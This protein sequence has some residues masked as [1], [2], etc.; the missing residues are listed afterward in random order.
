MILGSLC[1]V[2][3]V[4]LGEPLAPGMQ[5]PVITLADQ[6]DVEAKIGP[7]T[8]LLVFARDMDAAKIVE[9][10]LEE[11]GAAILA[12]AA[13]VFVSDIHR[14]PGIITRLFALPSMRKRPYRMLLDREGAATADLPSQDEKV[15]LIR[16][17]K[18]KIESV[19]YIDSATALRA[20]LVAAEP[21]TDPKM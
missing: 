15:S 18:L 1:L 8:R 21:A 4:A 16:L 3:R 19:D 12:D 5:L 20:A 11:N 14:M 10:A 9:E 17:D 2:I 7:E 13:A 6:H